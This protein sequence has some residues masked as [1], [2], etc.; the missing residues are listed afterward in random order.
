MYP[1]GRLARL[2]WQA[3]L[4]LQRRRALEQLNK[5]RGVEICLDEYSYHS[6]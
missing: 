6:P 1:Q 5:G 4:E 2:H 3:G